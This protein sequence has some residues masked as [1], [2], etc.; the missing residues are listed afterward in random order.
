MIVDP[1]C[2]A[3]GSSNVAVCQLLGHTYP[4][5]T[6]QPEPIVIEL[7]GKTPAKKN[8][9]HPRR[10]G[11]VGI[12]DPA[13]QT[14]IDRMAMQIPGHVRDLKL[15]SPEIHFHFF[16]EKAN[17][18]RDNAVTTLLDILVKYGTLQDDNVAQCNGPILIHPAER[19]DED[20]VKIIL[21]PIA[22]QPAS[23]RYVR[24]PKRKSLAPIP[25]IL[26]DKSTPMEDD[27]PD[28]MEDSAW[29]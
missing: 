12:T 1:T 22:Q 16:Y 25:I 18:D 21:F 23:P 11:G 6:M 17:W 3:C 29:E 15:V 4:I 20:S 9:W 5:E 14:M 13:I 19:S 7:R 24:P 8:N 26:N 27:F 2:I 28:L 10:G